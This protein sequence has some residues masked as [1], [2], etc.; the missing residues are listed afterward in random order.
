MWHP[1]PGQELMFRRLTGWLRQIFDFRASG[2]NEA[3]FVLLRVGLSCVLLFKLLYELRDFGDLYSSHGLVPWWANEISA[4]NY[5]PTLSWLFSVVNSFVSSVQ[6]ETVVM[7]VLGI[8][9]GGLVL[10]L[11]GQ[12]ERTAAI[13]V[14][15]THFVLMSSNRFT[16]YGVDAFASIG[17]FYIVIGSLIVNPQIARFQRVP[18]DGF[19][20]VVLMTLLRLQMCIVYAET[21][22]TKASGR[23]WWSGDSL[24]RTLQ[25]PQFQGLV[26]T[27]WLGSFPALVKAAAIC[28]I[29]VEIAY[30]VAMWIPKIRAVEL[31]SILVLHIMIMLTL[32]LWTFGAAMIVL[33]VA[34]FGLPAMQDLRAFFPTFGRGYIGELIAGKLQYTGARK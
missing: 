23:D 20:T 30:P 25:Q 21:G 22:W 10:L 13:V 7:G 2:D 8:Y 27:H 14:W 12:W 33:N 29:V 32:S 18:S 26:G 31:I 34:A 9:A 5:V 19:G 11:I 17:L 6:P 16:L 28:V 24:W 15:L 3:S 1:L 4:P